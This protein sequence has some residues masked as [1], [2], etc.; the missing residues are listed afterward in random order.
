LPSPLAGTRAAVRCDSRD[1]AITC[2]LQSEMIGDEHAPALAR[3]SLGN[4]SSKMVFAES[5]AGPRGCMA[6]AG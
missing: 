2:G 3:D 1:P 5:E 4:T 6:G